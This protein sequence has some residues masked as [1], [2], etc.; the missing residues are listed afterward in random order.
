MNG[1]HPI[2]LLLV[3]DSPRDKELIERELRRAQL[4]F[5]MAV[6]DDEEGFRSELESS[7]PDVILSDYHLPRFD[8]VRALQ[9][10]RTIAPST[11][12]IFVSGSIG[13]ERAVQALREGATDYVLKD[14]LSRLASAIV[15]ALAERRERVLRQN[16]ETALR[17]SEQRFQ[18][19]ASAT[20]EIIWD[21]NL[22]TSRI[23]FSGAMRDFW[24][25]D[26][27]QPD[28]EA[29]WFERRIHPADRA[30]ALASLQEAAARKERW[31]AEFRFARADDTFSHVLLRGLVV[32]DAQGAPVRL[33]GAIFDITERLQLEQFR[34]IESLG[35]VAATVAHEFNNV[36]MGMLPVAHRMARGPLPEEMNTRMAGLIMHSVSRGRRLTEQILSFSKPAEPEPIPIALDEWLHDLAPELRA[37][38]GNA[39]V[40]IRA[41]SFLVSIDP[42]QM[43]QVLSN[44]V[45]N[46][47]HAMPAG[48]TI[49]I[50]TDAGDD[51]V[52]LTVT[53]EGTGMSPETL[54]QI[55]EPLFTTKRSG[56][57]LGLAVAQQIIARHHGTIR[58]SSKVGKGTT[59][60][61]V[62]PLAEARVN[63]RTG[64][65]R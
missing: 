7:D 12:F 53:D 48:G 47:S 14:R 5:S 54:E 44:L 45:V 65:R 24:G 46:A 52:S 1:A 21:W 61:I 17:A 31:S 57:G 37:L 30:E 2:R 27:P 50:A 58:V 51:N 43:Q 13:E 3:E 59:F 16:V 36:L 23:W 25:H 29:S 60:E 10:A 56:T 22:V 26:L 18:Y 35:R 32:R 6:V 20:R 33:I 11:P 39:T 38:A 19:A 63:L 40:D 15:R 49:T 64:T 8:G 62:L 55:F 42:P 9:I 41:S 34:R 28:V 4:L